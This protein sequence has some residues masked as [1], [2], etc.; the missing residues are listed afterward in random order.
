[1]RVYFTMRTDALYE[2]YSMTNCVNRRSL[3]TRVNFFELS[4][5]LVLLKTVFKLAAHDEDSK[6]T[7]RDSTILTMQVFLEH[8]SGDESHIILFPLKPTS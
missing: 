4:N 2:S 8:P 3:N 7:Y 1:M 6:F 5:C